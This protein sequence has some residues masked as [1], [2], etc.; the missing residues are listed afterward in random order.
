MPH[1]LVE[2]MWRVRGRAPCHAARTS[3]IGPRGGYRRAAR[4]ASAPVGAPG[5]GLMLSPSK[6]L[7][8]YGVLCRRS[9]AFHL[10]LARPPWGAAACRGRPG[11]GRGLLAYGPAEH[12][13]ADPGGQ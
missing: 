3:M 9:T 11:G 12:A 2:R 7:L 6:E 8:Y 4:G 10:A 1:Q 5:R 13:A